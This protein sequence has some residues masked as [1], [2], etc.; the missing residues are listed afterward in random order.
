MP[1]MKFKTF[2]DL[3]RFEKE[4]KGITWQFSPDKAYLERALRFQIRIPFYPGL[5]KF[6]SFEEA[7]KWEM[8][9]WKGGFS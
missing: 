2:E 9:W 7:E 5:Y 3:D 6:K 1:V 8:H 4:G